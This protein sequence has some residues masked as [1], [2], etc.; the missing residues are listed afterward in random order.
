MGKIHMGRVLLGGLLA[1]VVLFFTEFVLQGVLLKGQWDAAL[2]E[3][4]QV[5]A[6]L[7]RLNADQDRIRKNLRE[8]PKDAEVY[9][10]YLKKLSAQEKEIDS[11][12]A[13]QK[14]LM[15]DEFAAKKAFE[16][17]LSTLTD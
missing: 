9:D 17:Y 6:D 13:K 2:R 15:A 14:K 11:L 16:N 3:L 12:T 1:G 5:S 7:A 10:T 8:T 4:N